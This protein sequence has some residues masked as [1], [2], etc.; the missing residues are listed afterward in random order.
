MERVIGYH[1]IADE[2]ETKIR[3]GPSGNVDG[4]LAHLDQLKTALDFFSQNNPESVEMGHVV[5][6]FDSGLEALSRE[7]LQLL[8]KFSKPVP[9][10]TLHDVAAS[11]DSEGTDW[12]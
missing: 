11:E 5:E 8:K 6:L 2:V 1:N 10:A 12:H 3:E 9:I 4:Y 7:F